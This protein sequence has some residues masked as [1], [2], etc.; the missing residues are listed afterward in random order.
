M[1]FIDVGLKI[2]T[3]YLVQGMM[4]YINLVKECVISCLKIRIDNKC[5]GNR[6]KTR[7][8]TIQMYK[9]AYYGKEWP[10]HFK[11]SDALN[12]TF[13][14]MLYGIGM[15]I[16][17]P[18]AMIIISNQR[19]AERVQVAYNMRQPPAMDDA[20]SKSVLSIL[21]F[22]P[23]FLLFNGFWMLD[24]RQYFDNVWIYKNKVTHNMMSGH[25]PNFKVNQASPMLLAGFLCLVIVLIQMVVPDDMLKRSGFTMAREDMQV[26]EDLPNF[27]KALPIS[28]SDM[29][30][31]EHEHMQAEYGFE[32]QDCN[33]I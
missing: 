7:S 15:P 19:L 9:A 33:F 22:A 24:N 5:S 14:A 27:F 4:P 28:Q 13:L 29:L 25:F 32:L 20:L 3:T 2:I 30:I 23:I 21:K 17:F 16:M 12:I 1:W 18:M 6:F 10:V 31:A 26:D 8:H 11:Y